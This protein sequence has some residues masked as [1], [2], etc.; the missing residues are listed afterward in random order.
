MPPHLAD[1]VLETLELVPLGGLGQ[2]VYARPDP[3]QAIGREPTLDAGGAVVVATGREPPRLAAVVRDQ[4][5]EPRQS[6]AAELREDERLV[7]A[8]LGVAVRAPE[9][10]RPACEF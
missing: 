4:F 1:L 5:V 8:R 9:P 3:V 6:P 7:A 10:D 2:V